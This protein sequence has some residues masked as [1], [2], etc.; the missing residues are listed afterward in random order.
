MPICIHSG[1]GSFN[2]HDFFE[3][4]SGFTQFKLA[5]VGAFHS[6]IYHEIPEK[7]PTLRFGIIEV[8]AQWVPYAIHDLAKRFQRRSKELKKNLLQENRIW[9]ACQTDDD[10]SYILQYTGEDNLVIGS[11]YG[12]ADTAT[13][14]DALRNLQHDGKVNPRVVNKILDDNP[15]RLYAL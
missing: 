14:I 3:Q 7:F 15:R 5:V 10:L 11:D 1:N 8:S 9:V 6:L 12:H 2:I 13:E 4:D